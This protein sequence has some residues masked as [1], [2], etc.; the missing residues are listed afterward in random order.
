MATFNYFMSFIEDPEDREFVKAS[1]GAVIRGNRLPQ[2]LLLCGP[3]GSGKSTLMNLA[4]FMTQQPY[5]TFGMYSQ[6]RDLFAQVPDG[7][8][9]N[10][11]HVYMNPD[12]DT[13]FQPIIFGPEPNTGQFQFLGSIAQH[14]FSAFQKRV[15]DKVEVPPWKAPILVDSPH[16]VHLP[17]FK[18]VQITSPG[19]E[20]LDPMLSKKLEKEAPEIKAECIQAFEKYDNHPDKL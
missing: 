2:N 1:I 7:M 11:K 14:G 8:G 12:G 15:L 6:Q 19:M 4:K 10:T 17:G 13:L 9:K 20:N 3:S 18:L 5:T 16:I